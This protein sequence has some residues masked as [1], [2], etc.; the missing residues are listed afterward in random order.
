MTTIALLGNP[1]SGKTTLFNELTGSNQRVGNWPGVTV[2][3]KEGRIKGQKDLTLT[4]LPGI[5]S[6]SPYT[7]EEIVARDY[8]L[9]GQPD[10]IINIVDATNLERNL[11]LTTQALETGIPVVI[12]L[13]MMDLIEKRGQSIDTAALSKALGGTP[14][15]PIS[16]LEKTGSQD[17]VQ[18][19]LKVAG[20]APPAS[21]LTF[22]D[23]V[24]KSLAAIRQ[25][26]GLQGPQARYY[27]I[28]CFEGDD[29]VI[30]DLHLS[31][32]AQHDIQE[33]IRQAEDDADLD[34]ESMITN[35]RYDFIASWMPQVAS[36]P[37]VTQK[38]SFSDK[39]DKVLTSRIW[40]LP[41]FFLVMFVVYAVSI[42]GVGGSTQDWMGGLFESLGGMAEAAMTSVN[43]A[44]WLIDL[45]V[46]GIIAGVGAILTF[47]PQIMILYIFLSFLEGCGYMSRVAFI[48]DRL[49]RPFG[50][51][52][53]SFIPFLM[54]TGCAVPA[55]MATRTIESEKDRRLTIM[56]TS[57]MPCGAKLPIIAMIAGAFFPENPFIAPGVYFI[58][59]GGILLSCFI[60][61]R[62][63][64]FKGEAAPFII[65]LPE[66]RLPKVSYVLAMMWEKA[67]LFI[68]KA[69]TVIFVSS[70]I[71]WFLSSYDFRFQAVPADASMMA[72][73]G[74]IFAPLFQP[75]GFGTWQAVAG[76]LAG[77]VAK[78]NLVSTLGVL[79]GVGEAIEGTEVGILAAIQ[80]HFT[81]ASGLAYLVF[82][83]FWIPCIASMG[84]IRS[85]M[86]SWKWTGF[87]FAYQT[88]F[89]Y[90]MAF[91]TY[92]IGSLII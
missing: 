21:P 82:N 66:Y 12:A 65:E 88:I 68:R 44:P 11:Y 69:G 34:A 87:T 89:A 26:A 92:Q 4:D 59:I 7:P 42:Q 39:L 24:E 36:R 62:T 70:V 37:S 40:G 33:V 48:M 19:A 72:A 32:E 29:K 45:V 13:N 56:T 83:M 81:A 18:A 76:S 14:V 49:F 23:P 77:L 90:L 57:F 31:S 58:S 35:G 73:I 3:K 53:K 27:A 20:Q 67:W 10:A 79:Y 54:A 28:K 22:A 91:L 1:N 46:N 85:E 6:L 63:A 8:L 50:L 80:A 38:E 64:W 61:K 71:I 5:Y 52:G 41:I 55:I 2:E 51:S 47:V 60:L 16:A 30:Q 17:L 75:L 25:I 74:S 43:T 9:Q 84:A 15:V 78:E 86:G